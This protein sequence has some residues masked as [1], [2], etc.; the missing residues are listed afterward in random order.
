MKNIATRSQVWQRP[1]FHLDP[2]AEQLD[3]LD[4]LVLRERTIE[5]AAA[6]L[7][8]EDRDHHASIEIDCRH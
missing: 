7:A 8:A 1:R 5:R 4:E 2:V 6:A 3:G